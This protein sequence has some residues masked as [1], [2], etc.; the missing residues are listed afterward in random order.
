MPSDDSDRA[1]L[2]QQVE[3]FA[4]TVVGP[5]AQ[6]LEDGSLDELRAVLDQMDNL[7]LL[8]PCDPAL[9]VDAV[10]ALSGELAAAGVLVLTHHVAQGLAAPEEGAL[11]GTTIYAEP[12]D[13][14]ELEL[15]SD[16]A[17]CVSGRAELV[18]GAP[19]AEDLILA[20][21]SPNDELAL[22]RVATAEG[23]VGAPLHTLG[24]RACP[25][26]DVT[27]DAARCRVLARGAA[28]ADRLERTRRT[29]AAGVAAVCAGIA[30]RSTDTAV[31]YARERKQGGCAIIEHDAVRELLAEMTADTLTAELAVPTLLD[32]G[33][34]P[35]LRM[36]L[37]RV[38]QSVARATRS[39]VQVLGGYGYLKDYLQER[40]MRDGR[41][42][43]LLL[44]R[45]ATDVLRAFDVPERR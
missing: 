4:A 5:R 40:R 33:P 30:R 41:Q 34:E 38:K 39:G 32:G 13:V 23:R 25:T 22:I 27:F 1:L 24:M 21:R 7:G 12:D 14:P 10:G 45:A 3:R 20:A 44:G 16:E 35:A 8:A 19:L 6:A 26:A 11:F 18:V 17:P 9:V 42:A 37:A 43:G 2:R 28:A 29:Y 36:L 31:A 15:A